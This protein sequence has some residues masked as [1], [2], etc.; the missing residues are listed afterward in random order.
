MALNDARISRPR[1]VQCLD[2]PLAR[3]IGGCQPSTPVVVGWNASWR[4]GEEPLR[5]MSWRC[6]GVI[7]RTRSRVFF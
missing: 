7:C 6:S 1:L 5:A 2:I 4:R 3:F